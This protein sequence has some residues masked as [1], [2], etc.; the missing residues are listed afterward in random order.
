MDT[1][2]A[3]F[4]IILIIFL[5]HTGNG[6]YFSLRNFFHTIEKLSL[7][8]LAKRIK[9]RLAKILILFPTKMKPVKK[10]LW[11]VK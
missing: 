5:T 1:F 7:E 9:Y 4:I 8:E 11:L 2:H 6:K 3:V 10:V